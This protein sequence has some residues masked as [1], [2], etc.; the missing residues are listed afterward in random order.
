[1]CHLQTR[2]AATGSRQTTLLWELL[3]PAPP[4]SL[5]YRCH[6]VYV[7]TLHNTF[8][9]SISGLLTTITDLCTLA[10]VSIAENQKNPTQMKRDSAKNGH[11]E[12]VLV[13]L[14]CP[15]PLAGT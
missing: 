5:R 14:D 4:S 8:L 12:V 10:C 9:F 1:M 2:E 13:L 15:A 6:Q 3:A 11:Q 7:H